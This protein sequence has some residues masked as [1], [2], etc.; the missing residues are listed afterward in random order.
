MQD[1]ISYSGDTYTN[2]YSPKRK[3]NKGSKFKPIKMKCSKCGTTKGQIDLH[4]ID[5]NRNNSSRSNLRAMCRS[6]HRSKHDGKSNI[7]EVISSAARIIEDPNTKASQAIAKAHQNED[8]MHVEFILC[9][10]DANANKDF[11]TSEDMEENA[12][13]AV[14][15]PINW[16]HSTKNIGVIYDANFISIAKLADDKK[17]KEYY[18]QVDPLEKDFIVCKAAIWEYKHPEEARVMRSRN[19]SGILFFSMENKFGSA[20]CSECKEEYSSVY[21]YCEHLLTRRDNASNA[22]RV[23]VNSNYVG[24]GVTAGP[25]DKGAKTLALANE[26]SGPVLYDLG[27]LDRQEYINYL[28]WGGNVRKG[29]DIPSNYDTE[30]EIDSQFFADDINS[31]FPLDGA[32]NIR[33]TAKALILEPEAVTNYDENELIYMIER[34]VK[35]AKEYNVDISD[36]VK[37]GSNIV[38]TTNITESPEFKAALKDA[39]AKLENGARLKELEDEVKN[40]STALDEEKKS[41]TKAKADAEATEKEFNEFKENEKAEKLAQARLS[42]LNEKGFEFSDDTKKIVFSCATNLDDENFNSFV[43]LLTEVKENAIAAHMKEEEEK[44]KDKKKKKGDKD[45]D[46]KKDIVKASQDE[47]GKTALAS[48]DDDPDNNSF[49]SRLDRV[50]IELGNREGLSYEKKEG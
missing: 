34:T 50:F 23:F 27:L 49:G 13:T 47:E 38:N 41:S 5:G 2:R 44:D 36:I 18:S 33:V 8:L 19:D 37:G 28:A 30:G 40:I 20:K 21:D 46:E 42:D 7:A 12:I 32:D 9:H 11:F 4:H 3:H 43:D 24:A 25:A 15:K 31:H 10:N 35:A 48:I 26:G 6:C 39:Q 22:N 29:I 16:E 17:A 14:N 45:K 1:N